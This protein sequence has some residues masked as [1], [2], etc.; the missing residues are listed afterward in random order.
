MSDRN[1]TTFR[2]TGDIR[3]LVFSAIEETGIPHGII[4]RQ[5]GLSPDPWASL[6]V[7]GTVGDDPARVRENR[8]R[9]FEAFH[10]S[11]ESIFDVWQVHSADVAF[12]DKPRNPEVPYQKADVVLTDR[13]EITLFMR[14][15]DCVPILL[16]DPFRQ[17][18]GIVHAG[19]IGTVN[20]VA[21]AAVN[22]MQS[23]Y[24]SV[25]RNIR[26]AI[27]PSICVNH[28]PVGPEV[29]DQVKNAFGKQSF[30][31][32]IRMGDRDHFDLWEANRLILQEA[33][34]GCISESRICTAEHLEDWF[35][36]RGEQGKTG[37]FGAII[38]PGGGDGWKPLNR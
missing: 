19:W 7:G 13:P 4:T 17:V 36:H 30:R 22:A 3:Y 1:K 37:R 8:Y 5:G 10:R 12:G 21:E 38:T 14:F 25:P 15:A 18:V 11:R 26:A 32:L 31:V 29:T 16:V 2:Q 35:S 28:Y 33:G 27:G 23:R 9:T 34:V 24:A 6:N 20:R